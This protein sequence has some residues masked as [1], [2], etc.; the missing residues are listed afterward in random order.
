MNERN[1]ADGDM[2]GQENAGDRHEQMM[3]A[4]DQSSD[5]RGIGENGTT[6]LGDA[7]NVAGGTGPGG[8]MS[9]SA[10]G[11]TGGGMEQEQ[12][13][14]GSTGQAGYG[15]QSGAMGGT[16]G[17]QDGNQTGGQMGGMS[18]DGSAMSQQS[19]EE[20]NPDGRKLFSSDDEEEND[21]LGEGM[22]SAS[23]AG[24]SI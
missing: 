5:F 17:G 16:T 15:D 20:M 12:P 19:G 18:D 10:A 11:G 21:D 13:G 6:N 7:R 14:Y 22:S 2:S 1:R 4:Q 9:G 3:Q 24:T 8:T 23:A